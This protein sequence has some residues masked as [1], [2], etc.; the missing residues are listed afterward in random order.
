MGSH[1]ATPGAGCILEMNGTA[2]MAEV[3]WIFRAPFPC[4]LRIW[5]INRQQSDVSNHNLWTSIGH[6]VSHDLRKGR[7]CQNPSPQHQET[8][9][10]AFFVRGGL[11]ARQFVHTLDQR[12]ADLPAYH[13]MDGIH[14][15][16]PS[17]VQTRQTRQEDYIIPASLAD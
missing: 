12:K 9:S 16:E 15:R 3:D 1:E 7:A 6:L 11:V 5:G 4:Q 2:I 17:A 13:P 10:R 8:M 14:T